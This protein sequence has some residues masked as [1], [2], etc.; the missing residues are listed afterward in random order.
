[1]KDKDKSHF[2]E[3]NSEMTSE[4]YDSFTGTIKT[5]KEHK[6]DMDLW[7]ETNKLASDSTEYIKKSSETIYSSYKHESSE[8]GSQSNINKYTESDIVSKYSTNINSEKDINSI[9]HTIITE[10]NIIDTSDNIS[11]VS[12]NEN[13]YISESIIDSKINEKNTNDISDKSYDKYTTD[14]T[15]ESSSKLTTNWITN[16]NELSEIVSYSNKGINENKTKYS[17]EITSNSSF[18]AIKQ[19]DS[20]IKT[21]DIYESSQNFYDK[22]TNENKHINLTESSLFTEI[23]ISEDT[24]KMKSNYSSEKI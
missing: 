18:D 23:K 19:S 22:N 9:S 17:S 3:T 13:T 16:E 12:T 6:T 15:S 4:I 5:N 21:S 8:I 7:T 14:I 2:I 24:E 20:I 11:T 10:N 1:M